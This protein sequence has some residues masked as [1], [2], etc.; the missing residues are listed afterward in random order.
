MNELTQILSETTERLL[1]D[2]AGKATVKAAEEGQ[3]PEALW[4]ALE[5]NGLTQPL[6]PEQQGGIGTG[7]EDVFV[8]ALAAGRHRAPVPLP[9]TIAAGWLLAA[10]GISVPAGPIALADDLDAVAWGAVVPHAVAVA[11][12]GGSWQ[13]QLL[14]RDG[15]DVAADLSIAGEPRDR[16]RYGGAIATGGLPLAAGNDAVS[17]VRLLGA[18][19]RAAQI[20]GAAGRAI[21]FAVEHAMTRRQFGRPIAKFQ[22]IQQTL[23][24]AAAYAAEARM[25]AHVAFRALEDGDLTRAEFAV[26]S[27]KVVGSEA[28]DVV[29]DAVHQ[30][31]GAIGFTEEHELHFTTRRMWSW[32]A[33]FGSSGF[34]AER[35][36]RA[37]LARGAANLWPDVVGANIATASGAMSAT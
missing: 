13:I 23:A 25:A 19:M 36:G 8:I 3:W 22:A 21:E 35:L 11:P 2:H 31:H 9:E 33:E 15:A 1:A 16:M 20:A 4:A 10:A 5:E 17:P 14:T 7:W 30:V 12:D 28:A 27:A 34:W 6:V 29:T 26:A 37:V 32:Q 24:R 18:A